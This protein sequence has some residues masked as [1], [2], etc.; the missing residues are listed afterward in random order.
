MDLWFEP[1]CCL[2]NLFHLTRIV[3]VQE[4][5][6]GGKRVG[7]NG[8]YGGGSVEWQVFHDAMHINGGY[9]SHFAQVAF[10][11]PVLAFRKVTATLFPAENFTG[12]SDLEAFRDALSRFTAGYFLSHRGR[13]M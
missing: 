3:E 7:R 12:S 2:K 1:G 13:R 9:Q 6:P 10:A 5:T 11:L 8:Q 4:G